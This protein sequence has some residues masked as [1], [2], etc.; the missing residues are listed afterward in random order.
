MASRR[1]AVTYDLLDS[2]GR[3]VYRG[4]TID[5]QRRQGQH[6]RAGKQFSRMQVTSD[7]MANGDARTQERAFL[8]TYRGSHNGHLPKYNKSR[9]G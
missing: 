9:N 5:P 2:Y 7:R 4:Q 8:A 3:V 6:R 1:A